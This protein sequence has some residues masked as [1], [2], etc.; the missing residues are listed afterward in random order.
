MTSLYE[1]QV[2]IISD[3]TTNQSSACLDLNKGS[4]NNPTQPEIPGLA[5]FCEHMLFQGNQKY[6]EENYFN[7]FVKKYSGSKNA[8]TGS[9]NTYYFFQISNEGFEPAL[10]IWSYFFKSPLMK[11]DCVDREVNAVNSENEKNL[12]IDSRRLH[13]IKKLL[14]NSPFNNFGCGNLET[15]E[16][17]PKQLGLNLHENVKKF[18]DENYSSNL[19]KL[20]LISNL[21]L[22]AME[23]MVVEKFSDIENKNFPVDVYEYEKLHTSVENRAKILYYLPVKETRT[24]RLEFYQPN[25]WA[26]TPSCSP[27]KIMGHL[28]GHESQGSICYYLKKLNYI[29]GLSSGGYPCY[30]GINLMSV[31]IQ[32]TE[33]GLEKFKEVTKIVFEYIEM[34]KIELA[35][36]GYDYLWNEQKQHYMNQFT[37]LENTKRLRSC[38]DRIWESLIS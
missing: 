8:A 11:Q 32:L 35:K 4:F 1:L 38:F 6:P 25:L 23:K 28:I 37:F 9:E 19:M 5:H 2:L 36:G 22:E 21:D 17:K 31:T 27:D 16:T 20:T 13:Q 24:L 7:E 18:F 34:L 14:M 26:D 3:R 15:L 12:K 29:T 30:R 10:D 33:L